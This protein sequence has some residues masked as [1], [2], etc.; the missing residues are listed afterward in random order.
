MERG[1]ELHGGGGALV[2]VLSMFGLSLNGVGPATDVLET[3][4]LHTCQG[5]V[6]PP[7][8]R[9]VAPTDISE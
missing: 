7:G 5:S 6:P 8:A 1:W 3:R 9:A 2:T 4:V